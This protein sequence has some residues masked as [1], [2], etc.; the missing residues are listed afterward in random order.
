MR[1]VSGLRELLQTVETSPRR[2]ARKDWAAGSPRHRPI[3]S[4]VLEATGS[5]RSAFSSPIRQCQT[6]SKDRHRKASENIVHTSKIRRALLR[7]NLLSRADRW[8]K[9]NLRHHHIRFCLLFLTY[10]SWHLADV[11]NVWK[12]I[13]VCYR[14][15]M[16]KK[17]GNKRL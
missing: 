10:I 13:N 15:F 11:I 3:S 4:D 12:K 17:Y 2:L 14:V 5:T 6:L 8:T 9:Y 16:E 1:C 7:F